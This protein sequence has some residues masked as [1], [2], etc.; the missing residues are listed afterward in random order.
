MKKYIFIT[1]LVLYSLL[2]YSQD[3]A[4]HKITNIIGAGRVEINIGEQNEIKV[5]DV[6]QVFGKGQIIH[7]ATGKLVERDNI[8][9]GKIK[10]IEVKEL[11]S[12]AETIEKKG[13]FS[14]GNKIVKVVSIEQ[15]I[16]ENKRP[17]QA[18][19]EN[20]KERNYAETIYS[21]K[22]KK[23]KS[24]KDVHIIEIKEE[25][26]QQIAIIDKGKVTKAKGGYPVVGKKY[27]VFVPIVDTSS[28][29]GQQLIEGEEY[30]GEVKI[31]SVE[32]DAST[33][34]MLLNKNVSY[35]FI[36]KDNI[37]RTYI[38]KYKGFHHIFY[39]NAASLNINLGNKPIS[40]LNGIYTVHGYLTNPHF[41]IGAGIGY[42]IEYH[43]DYA[44]ALIKNIPLFINTR[45]YI[46]NSK[47]TPFISLSLGKNNVLNKSDEGRLYDLKGKLFFGC[48]IGLKSYLKN[49]NAILYEF[50]FKY[51]MYDFSY[52]NSID[53]NTINSYDA[54]IPIFN[55]TIGYSF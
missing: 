4:E 11:S 46:L 37:L 5:N 55:F 31:T 54:D 22:E 44:E 12:I 7:P 17:I 20:P 28:I 49:K 43:D 1:F 10:V 50:N 33:G 16:V 51:S 39:F 35:D 21:Q 34:N 41:F 40:A 45:Y 8:Y 36:E 19:F 2:V 3:G 26:K 48:G 23:T 24:N 47:T 32:H 27:F 53:L 13:E 42:E 29:T 15:E 38:P 25:N 30:I 9:L 6:F 52:P 14:E 18:E